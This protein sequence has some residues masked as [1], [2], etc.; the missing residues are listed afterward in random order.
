MKTEIIRAEPTVKSESFFPLLRE[1]IN[2]KYVVLFNREYSGT[3]IHTD[4]NFKL[5]L[6]LGNY[7]ANW[8]SCFDESCWQAFTDTIKITT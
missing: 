2:G 1:H 5:D 3:V 6:K 7:Y 4:E 8:V